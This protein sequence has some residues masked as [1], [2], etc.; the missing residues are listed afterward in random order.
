MWADPATERILTPAT[1]ITFIRTIAC[2]TIV[3]FAVNKGVP[4][5]GEFWS[6]ALKLMAIAL[7]VFWAGDS[8]D[9]Q[10]ARRMHHETRY[11][12]LLDIMSDRLCCAAFYFGLA[13]LH[14]ELLQPWLPLVWSQ[15]HLRLPGASWVK[16]QRWQTEHQR[17]SGC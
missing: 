17:Y 11:G 5:D 13:W 1:I 8:L 3:G 16:R 2:V 10:V 12:A 6:P 4:A 15:S 9:G 14:P 7:V